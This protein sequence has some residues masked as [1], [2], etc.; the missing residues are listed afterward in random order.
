MSAHPVVL[1]GGGVSGLFARAALAQAGVPTILLENAALGSGQ[2]IASQGILHRG[3]KYA[4]SSAATQAADELARAQVLWEESMTGDESSPRIVDLRQLRVL[5]RTMYLWTRPGVLASVAGNLTGTAAALAM[6]SGVVKLQPSTFPAAFAGA[7]GG[8]HVWEVTETCIDPQS[9]L[10]LLARSHATDLQHPIIQL[11]RERSPLQVAAFYQPRAVILSAGCGNEELLTAFGQNPTT[12]CQRRPLRMVIM[13]N[14]PFDFFAHCL[15]ELSDKPRLTIT[16]S[17]SPSGERIW[18]IG[19]E[20]AESGVSRDDAAQIDAARNELKRCLPWV[21]LPP[22][23]SWSTYVVDRAEG[24]TQAGTRPDGPV[25]H[26]LTCTLADRHVPLLA[27]WPTKLALAPAMA[28]QIVTLLSRLALP[29][30]KLHSPAPEVVPAAT[31]PVAIAGYPW[32]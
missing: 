26:E 21:P 22:A 29:Q 6:K 32:M 13:R 28:A 31:A 9:L 15:Q 18:Y 16:S 14:A 19:G 3:V 25:I 2:T 17:Q 7:P 11:D 1:F 27:C 4:L 30:H 5:T 24:K 20:I 23:H 10:T 12:L 8:V